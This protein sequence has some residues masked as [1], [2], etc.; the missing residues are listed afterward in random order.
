LIDDQLNNSRSSGS[1]CDLELIEVKEN[2]PEL[3]EKFFE[4]VLKLYLKEMYKDLI[5]REMEENPKHLSFKV[6]SEVRR[7]L[8]LSIL[9][10]Q[11]SSRIGSLKCLTRI[12]IGRSQKKNSLQE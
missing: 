1:E 12:M 8:T 11:A 5:N 7:T 4:S 3:E 2:D 10:F 6:F 9:N